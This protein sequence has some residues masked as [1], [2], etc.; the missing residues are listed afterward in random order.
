MIGRIIRVARSC[1]NAS[2]IQHEGAA[3]V[4][5]RPPARCD[6][7]LRGAFP[8]GLDAGSPEADSLYGRQLQHEDEVVVGSDAVVTLEA[9][10]GASMHNGVLAVTSRERADRR[11][12]AAAAA[13][14][15]AR[16]AAV[17]VAG[18][19]AERTVVPVPP[20]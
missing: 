2:P 9:A 5:G 12:R 17:D 11:H 3:E 6:A 8:L 19:E 14:A 16:L 13:R 4:S 20:A 15:V 10:I 18:V 7:S 1:P